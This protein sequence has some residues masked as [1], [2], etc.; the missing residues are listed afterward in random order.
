MRELPIFTD[1][2][3]HLVSQLSA[4]TADSMVI[5]AEGKSLWPRMLNIVVTGECEVAVDPGEEHGIRITREM[6]LGMVKT[7]SN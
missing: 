2:K 4:Q 6:I 7:H 3:H 5:E 1:P